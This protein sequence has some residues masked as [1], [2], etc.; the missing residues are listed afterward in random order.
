MKIYTF[1]IKGRDVEM[2]FR[3]GNLAYTF[4]RD[5]KTYGYKVELKNKKTMDIVAAT[6]LL[7]INAIETIELLDANENKT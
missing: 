4:E 6:S 3:K 7:I 5:G 1:T 2:T